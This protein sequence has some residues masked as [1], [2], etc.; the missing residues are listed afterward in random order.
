M[1]KRENVRERHTQTQTHKYTTGGCIIGRTCFA[2][3][4]TVATNTVRTYNIIALLRKAWLRERAPT[5]R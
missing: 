4:M 2:F 1:R 5:L 3:Q